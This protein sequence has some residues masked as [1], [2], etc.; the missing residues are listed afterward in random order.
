MSAMELR[1]L[2][3]FLVVGEVLNFTKAAARL[4]V[5]Q[6]ALS[7]QVQDLEDEIGVDL[8]RRGQR[9]VSLT[10]EGKL[11]LE[12]ARELLKR[13]DESVERVRA[14]ACGEYWELQVGYSATPS[15]EILPDALATFRKAVP[16]VKL[17]L[18]DLFDDEIVAR[19]RD[20]TLELAVNAADNLQRI[21]R[22][23][24]KMADAADFRQRSRDN[25]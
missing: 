11:F 2:R 4:R 23:V 20:G 18:H 5:A 1:H 19:L 6:P 22:V 13:A 3:Y 14:L 9:G 16:R 7:R 15:W 8:L 21:A 10:A 25:V 12:E 24:G 17:I